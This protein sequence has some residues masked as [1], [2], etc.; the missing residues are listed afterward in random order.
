MTA[1]KK[2]GGYKRRL[3][4][5]SVKK[6]SPKTKKQNNKTKPQ[7]KKP[8]AKKNTPKM[9]R[10]K[11]IKAA[12]KRKKPQLSVA[13]SKAKKKSTASITNRQDRVKIKVFGV[14]G[15]GGNAL[16]RMRRNSEVRGIEFVAVNTDIQDLEKTDARKKI[17]IGK[18]LTRGL[19][20]GMNPDLGEQAAE[21]SR[22][23]LE[24]AVSGADLIFITAGMGG[25]T[26]SGASPILA[27]LAKE[28]GALTIAIVTKPFAF[29]GAPRSKVAED[30]LAKLRDKV[31]A[32]IIVPNDK[33]FEIIKKETPLLKA[34]ERIDDVLRDAIQ[35]ITELIASSG[36]INVDFSDIKTIMRDAGS[37][38]VGVGIAKGQNRAAIAANY[39]LNS[40]LLEF[41]ADGA[42]GILFGI[43]GGRDVKMSEI[44][45]IARH[46]TSNTDPSARI[47][48][49][50]YQDRRIKKG[51]I[52]VTLIATGFEGPLQH[53]D[54][55]EV[56]SSFFNPEYEG[57]IID[58]TSQAAQRQNLFQ[59]K[60]TV[61][62]EKE[63]IA[64][65]P[66][67]NTREFKKKG[68][69]DTQEIENQQSDTE[70]DDADESNP[71]D[72]P[73]FL[74]KKKK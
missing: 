4:K 55:G 59:K 14:G 48:F 71:W 8:V 68:K 17:H 34:F 35:G 57:E 36:M 60:K 41:N 21:E 28:A 29:E 54:D 19:G 49:G 67:D 39:A 66:V 64:D 16:S 56:G 73:A 3:K 44:N 5:T 69:A 50:A 1:P 31:D 62:E 6:A 22:A 27:E 13:P 46:I 25:G 10:F 26:G 12:A 58:L 30:A 7:G 2:L 42:R 32:L 45:E 9:R 53:L 11:K 20:T 37:A 65:E 74:R 24:N 52:K 33:I 72:I 15:G 47:I 18:Q 23:D 70:I 38:L 61:E 63:A 51:H 40:P 43:S